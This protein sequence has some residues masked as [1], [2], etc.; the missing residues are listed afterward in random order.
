MTQP[1]RERGRTPDWELRC[2][3]RNTEERGQIGAAW[4]NDDGSIRIKLNPCVTVPSDPMLL[5][6]LFKWDSQFQGK[7]QKV[8]YTQ[9][10]A[11]DLPF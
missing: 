6:T 2:L 9:Q 7:K 8:T 3:N 10:E 5:L 11:D 1:R 4:T